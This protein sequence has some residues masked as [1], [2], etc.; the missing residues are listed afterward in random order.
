M[1]QELPW[2]G[3]P[4]AA[5]FG[6]LDGAPTHRSA[7]RD[8]LRLPVSERVHDLGLGTRGLATPHFARYPVLAQSTFDRVGWNADDF[9]CYRF[10]MVYPPVPSIVM[11]ITR[12]PE[13]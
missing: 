7:A 4:T 6:R 2:P 5:V 9:R 10:T 11:L 1:H 13:R 12:L 8:R 3:P